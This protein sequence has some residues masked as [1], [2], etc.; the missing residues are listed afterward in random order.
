MING[1]M[2]AHKATAINKPWFSVY[3]FMLEKKETL[4]ADDVTKAVANIKHA[5]KASIKADYDIIYG[6]GKKHRKR[7]GDRYFTFEIC[8]KA[9]SNV[10]FAIP[11][12]YKKEAKNM[13]SSI[14]L[15]DEE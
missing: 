13:I 14:E 12:K 2:R 1:V 4:T 3:W 6:K 10:I 8:P 7:F 5:S 15:P 11:K 9:D